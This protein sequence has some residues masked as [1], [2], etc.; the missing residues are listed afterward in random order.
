MSSDVSAYRQVVQDQDAA[1]ATGD[2]GSFLSHTTQVKKHLECALWPNFF[3]TSTSCD[4]AL[5]GRQFGKRSA[6]QAYFAKVCSRVLNYAL[7]FDLLQYHFDRHVISHFSN[8]NAAA[9]GLSLDR[10]LKT[11]PDPPPDLHLA[12]LALVDLNC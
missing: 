1:L 10:S 3:P 8:A 5:Y 9:R 12:H 2:V 4:T 7:R 6:K 11:F